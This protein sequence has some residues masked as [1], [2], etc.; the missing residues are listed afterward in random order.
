[1]KYRKK[2]ISLFS[3]AVLYV[4]VFLICD[5]IFDVSG[6]F[7]IY[8]PGWTVRHF[9]WLAAAI[10]AI[11]IFFGWFWFPYITF[12]GYLLGNLFGELLGGF[13]SNIPPQYPHY[14]W[15]ICIAVFLLSCVVGM[16]VEKCG[17]KK[18]FYHQRRNI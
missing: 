12:V 2:V 8:T 17:K 3:I 5:N 13:W 18:I 11:P 10:S 14:G 1:M 6:I 7:P 9:L 4:V 15:I 16:W